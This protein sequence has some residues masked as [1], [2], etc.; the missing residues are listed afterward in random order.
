MTND[1][2]KALMAWAKATS[3][4][5]QLGLLAPNDEAVKSAKRAVDDALWALDE[6]V[7]A[8]L[9]STKGDPNAR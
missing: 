6:A 4:I 7:K 8:A 1:E 2:S 5:Y 9:I 3:G